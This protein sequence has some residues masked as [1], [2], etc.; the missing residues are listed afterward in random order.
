MSVAILFG[1]FVLLLALVLD[2]FGWGDSLSSAGN[3][4]VLISDVS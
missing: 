3:V 4:A 2:S 1:V